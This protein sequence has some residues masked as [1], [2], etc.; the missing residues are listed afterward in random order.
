[1]F[2][3][4]FVFEVY[5]WICFISLQLFHSEELLELHRGQGRIFIGETVTPAHLRMSIMKWSRKVSFHSN[6]NLSPTF[7]L[8]L[9]SPIFSLCASVLTKGLCTLEL[10]VT[11]QS[12]KL[13]M[14]VNI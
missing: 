6:L 10:H 7:D 5:F 14:T 3:Y 8:A 9:L 4:F 11:I 2:N 1:M 13:Q 12:Y